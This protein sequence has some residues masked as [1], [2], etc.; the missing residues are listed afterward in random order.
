MAENLRKAGLYFRDINAYWQLTQDAE[1][2]GRYPLDITK[3]ITTGHY[4]R[5]DD[6]AL[7]MVPSKFGRGFAHNYTTLCSFALGY[8]TFYLQTGQKWQLSKVIHVSE[9]ILRT[10]Q[11]LPNGAVLLRCEGEEGE[12][13]G[14]LSAM[15]QGEAMSVLCR[16][17]RATCNSRYLEAALGCLEPF[18]IQV[19]A[20]GVLGN[21]SMIN[22]PWYEEYPTVP[23]K[24]VLNG[25]IYSLWGLLDLAVATKNKRARELFDTG[26]DSLI[27]ALPYFEN[28]YWSLYWIPEEGDKY[29]A[30]IMYHNLHICQLTALHRQTEREEFRK[31]ARLFTEYARRPL[32]RMRAAASISRSKLLNL[33]RL[34]DH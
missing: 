22:V 9:Y 10:A 24:H 7:P 20:G 21:I 12:H 32:C 28:G 6:A 1:P 11:I 25:M 34:G 2:L 23:L 19:E 33:M 26:V 16:A 29:V 31:F 14:S 8:W 17:W 13:S 3:R 4:D 27:R 15:N 5:F 30:S 18:E